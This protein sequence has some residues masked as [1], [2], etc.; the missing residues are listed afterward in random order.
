M[1]E[2]AD[3]TLMLQYAAGNA[4]A[5][6]QLYERHKNPLYR[7]L[8]R[9]FNQNTA[10]ADELMQ[11]IWFSVIEARAQYQPNAKFTTWLYRIA[12]NRIV[13]EWRRRG[14]RSEFNQTDLSDGDTQISET[15]ADDAPEVDAQLFAQDCLQRFRL[16]LAGLPI[17]QRELV[18]L[19]E[20]TS[21]SL[22]DM[23]TLQ[24]V[25]RETVKS[26]L[27]YALNHLKK[28]LHDCL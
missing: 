11:D 15:T 25:G 20:D 12:R 28:V 16:E 2:T 4:D 19:R 18:V 8:L 7:Y 21:M 5:F 24:G 3:E 6:R 14:V 1:Q 17:E 22:L 10:V 23:A 26:R 27:R 13:D 9:G